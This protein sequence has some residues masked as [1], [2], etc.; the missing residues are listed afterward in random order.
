MQLEAIWRKKWLAL[1]IILLFGVAVR[2]SPLAAV[3]FRTDIPFG[4]GGLYLQFAKEI[5]TAG[6]SLPLRVSYY[7]LDGV[8]YVYPPLSFYVLALLLD[9]T[10]IGEFAAMNYLPT[11]LSCLTIVAFYAMTI[12]IFVEPRDVYVSSLIY[13]LLPAAFLEQA[14]GAGLVEGFGTCFY[15]LAV[16]A[17]HRL[18]RRD[19]FAS[20]ILLGVAIGLNVYSS[21]GSVYATA[22][23]VVVFWLFSSDGRCS[24]GKLLTAI[25]IGLL[26]SAPYWLTVSINHSPGIFT[27]TWFHQHS[28]K[29]AFA[30]LWFDTA[31]EP[32]LAIWTFLTLLGMLGH[33]FSGKYLKPAWFFATYLIPREFLYLAAVPMAILAAD[34]LRVLLLGIRQIPLSRGGR[35]LQ[36]RGIQ[37]SAIV[38]L[39]VFVYGAASAISASWS[40][41]VHGTNVRAEELSLMQ[42]IHQNT[43]ESSSFLV[44]GDEIEWFPEITERSTI[45][46]V[47]GSDWGKND[48]VYH[49][50][51]SVHSCDTVACC[52]EAAADHAITPDYIYVSKTPERFLM[53]KVAR[54]DPG[55]SVEQENSEA[56]LFRVNP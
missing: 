31:R 17:M 55:V 34:G 22:T 35:W 56:I 54:Q 9:L 6:Y 36:E 3:G 47:Q 8:P 28:I 30:K 2:L 45:N 25:F 39:L 1:S 20:A 43:G 50:N 21:P 18:N 48:W 42:W 32:H 19:D 27:Y 15:M 14:F 29:K 7:T 23:T 13:A 16:M 12:N 33:A 40:L 46:V 41:P 49:L 37:A 10:S 24:I 11:V 51:N 38:A 53:I 44:V 5:R 26:I 52:L 4:N